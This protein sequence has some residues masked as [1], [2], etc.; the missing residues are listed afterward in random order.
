[1]I[2][3]LISFLIIGGFPTHAKTAASNPRLLQRIARRLNTASTSS[4][5]KSNILP[6][7]KLFCDK[8]NELKLTCTSWSNCYHDDSEWIKTRTCQTDDSAK[9]QLYDS[10]PNRHSCTP[11]KVQIETLSARKEDF[12]IKRET[13]QKEAAQQA[14]KKA[15]ANKLLELETFIVDIYSSSLAIQKSMDSSLPHY[16]GATSMQ[17]FQL[18]SQFAQ[19]LAGMKIFYNAALSHTLRITDSKLFLMLNSESNDIS[20]RFVAIINEENAIS[21]RNAAQENYLLQQE[22]NLLEQHNYQ[23]RMRQIEKQNAQNQEFKK[24]CESMVARSAL[25]GSGL[26]AECR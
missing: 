6:K 14:Q 15:D 18:S 16:S 23:N 24:Y 11:S 20:K 12:R 9:C 5:Q 7:P 26:P 8:P 1:M 13:E 25:F 19:K 10:V 22:N 3:L 4:S 17:L 2:T 21:A